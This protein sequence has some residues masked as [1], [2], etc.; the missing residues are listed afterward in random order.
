MTF[1]RLNVMT[2]RQRYEA[3]VRP[4]MMAGDYQEFDTLAD[5]T[6][7]SWFYFVDGIPV[8]WCCLK[9]P[10]KYI[11]APQSYHML[12]NA[13]HADY[14]NRRIGAKMLD[15]RLSIAGH[16]PTSVCVQ[17]GNLAS[18]YLVRSRGFIEGEPNEIWTNWYKNYQS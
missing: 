13:V 10:S 4:I 6:I 9:S 12:G 1:V 15:Y 18:E 11:Q 14:R 5:P 7:T 17:P 8:G 3:L 16:Y 2:D